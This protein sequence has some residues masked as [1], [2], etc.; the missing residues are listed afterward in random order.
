[1]QTMES[2]TSQTGSDNLLADLMIG[3]VAGAAAIWVMDRVDWFNFKHESDEARRRTESVRPRGKPPAEVM[4]IRAAERLGSNPSPQQI[5]KVSKAVHY[6]LGIGPAMLYSAFQSR[7]P[8][9]TKG[10]GA[11]FGTGVFLLHDEGMNP[12]MGWSAKPTAYPWQAHARGLVAHLVYGLVTDALVRKM[13]GRRNASLQNA[14]DI[15]TIGS[16]T[17]VMSVSETVVVADQDE[18]TILTAD[19]TLVAGFEPVPPQPSS[20]AGIGS[21]TL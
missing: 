21:R 12:L 10:R 2:N 3:A 8:M 14:E 7:Y 9:I 15:E 11:L 19:E 6:T 18:A 13:K 16:T 5:K 17:A 20:G 1:M 4:T